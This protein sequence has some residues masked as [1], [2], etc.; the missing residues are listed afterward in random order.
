[1]TTRPT[2]SA[3]LVS[4]I[5]ANLIPLAGVWWYGWNVFGLFLTYWAESAVIATFTIIKMLRAQGEHPSSQTGIT[6]KQA[7]AS[8]ND[9]TT[10]T[11]NQ[12]SALFLVPFFCLHFGIFMLVHLVFIFA[13]FFSSHVSWLGLLT[14]IAG[15]GLSH[16]VSYQ[17]NFLDRG[18]YKVATPGDLFWRPYPRVI[19]MHLTIILGGMLALSTGQAAWALTLMVGLKIVIDLGSHVFEHALASQKIN[20]RTH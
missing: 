17:T 9:S 7:V 13:F 18:E 16:Y 6:L 12:G 11:S 19:V 14:A 4:L 15:L 8:W 10:V 20:A 3:A 2:T 1:M 5:M